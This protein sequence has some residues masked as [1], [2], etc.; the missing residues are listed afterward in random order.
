MALVA[1][2]KKAWTQHSAASLYQRGDIVK[3]IRTLLVLAFLTSV[4]GA[5]L[6]SMAAVQESSAQVGKT[7]NVE[8]IVDASGSM[9]APTNTGE[10]RMDSAKRVL[11]EVV[12]AIPDA[13]GV[14]VGLR[15]Y[16]HRGDNTDTGRPESC[17]SSDL[18]VPI[19]GVQKPELL[20]QVDALQPVGWTPIGYAL[21]QAS[22]DFNQPATDDVLNAVVIVT[23]GL[24]TCDA[25]PA[26]IASQ[27]R[28]SDAGI[29]THVIGF[30]TSQEE[31]AILSSIAEAGDG[32]LLSSDNTGQLMS[33]LFEVL[34]ELE[35][36]EETGSGET[37]ELP[38]GIGRVG[39][40]GDYDISVVFATHYS[41]TNYAEDRLAFIARVAVTY[42]GAT[43]GE[44]G[45][46][47]TFSSVG[48]LNTS[49]TTSND[50]CGQLPGRG[51]NSVNELFEGGSVEF[52]ICWVIDEEDADSLGMFVESISDLQGRRLWF[53]LSGA[54]STVAP[55]SQ[56]AAAD[57]SAT[58][59]ATF[60]VTMVDIQ[61]Q[62][63][64]LTIPANTDVTLSFVNAGVLSHSFN[65]DNPP[66]STGLLTGGMSSSVTVNLPPGVYQFYCDV[67]GHSE[68][69]MVGTIFAE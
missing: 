8:F 40:L 17:V 61:Y 16:G 42:R 50:S 55:E 51:P 46:D 68:A 4:Q 25:D 34:E 60:E 27:L 52:D 62:P 31:Q 20:A 69:G 30:G 14:N 64:E 45:S 37:R 47:L 48:N 9:A 65:M 15:V 24:E 44:P 2:L 36:V 41:G 19:D 12:N 67:P 63:T 43:S 18:L 38:L 28:T 21:E 11:T 32:Q 13:E 57:T 53:D 54:Q 33:A 56:E 22:A 49:Y 10:L 1:L 29:I 5:Q 26:S 58:S 66:V 39:T 7:V 6:S 35:V 3:L 23:D 59:Q